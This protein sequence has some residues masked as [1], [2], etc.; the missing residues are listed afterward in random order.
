M[1]YNE[2][3]KR[4]TMKYQKENL[5]HVK[6]FTGARFAICVTVSMSE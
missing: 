4:A 6:I 2:A 5:E 3:Q 1:A